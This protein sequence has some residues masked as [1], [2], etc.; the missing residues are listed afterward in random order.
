[1][2]GIV[3]KY[4]PEKFELKDGRICVIREIEVKDAAEMVE[5]LKTI[6]GE[7]DFL[8]SYPEEI[9]MS[10]EDEEPFD[11]VVSNPPY[12]KWKGDSDPVMINDPRLLQQEY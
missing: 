9:T 1:M 5:Y 2:W 10:A 12:S 4:T 6:M 3:T 11:I 8:N 7:S